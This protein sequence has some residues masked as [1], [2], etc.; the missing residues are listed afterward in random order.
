MSTYIPYN[1]ISGKKWTQLNHKDMSPR[2][3]KKPYKRS[4]D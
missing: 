1:M 2:S 4:I 3:N